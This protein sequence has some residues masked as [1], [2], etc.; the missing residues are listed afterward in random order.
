MQKDPG[1]HKGIHRELAILEFNAL[2][3]K[4][5]KKD[6]PEKAIM[7]LVEYVRNFGAKDLENIW[8]VEMMMAQF[9]YSKNHLPEALAHAKLSLDYAPE[10]YRSEVAQTLSFTR[11]QNFQ[12]VIF[13]I[14]LGI[15]KRKREG[16]ESS[17]SS[18]LFAFF[19][20]AHAKM[21]FSSCDRNVHQPP[22]FF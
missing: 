18:H 9:L 20:H 21:F 12:E 15:S 16:L 11:W 6:K 17:L 1:N 22:F 10:S 3:K 2:S 4:L 7:P 8:R 5:K 19:C 13:R 14:S